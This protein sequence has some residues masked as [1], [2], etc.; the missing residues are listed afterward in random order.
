[1]L[2]LLYIQENCVRA[3]SGRDMGGGRFQ[4]N[5]YALH[6]GEGV[7]NWQFLAYVLYG[8]PLSYVANVLEL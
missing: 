3:Y 2:Y 1:M 7:K 6:T 5:A 4:A 8:W